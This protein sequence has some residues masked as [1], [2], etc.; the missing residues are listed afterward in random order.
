MPLTVSI[1]LINAG[2]LSESRIEIDKTVL[3]A[4]P[5]SSDRYGHCINM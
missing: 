5:H 3:H 2:M 4:L 1:P